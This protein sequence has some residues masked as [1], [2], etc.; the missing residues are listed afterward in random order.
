MLP[1]W[2]LQ[3]ILTGALAGVGAWAAVRIELRYMKR[4]IE[5]AHWRLD[6]INAPPARLRL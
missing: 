5:A 4:A 2:V 3:A 1:D 6:K